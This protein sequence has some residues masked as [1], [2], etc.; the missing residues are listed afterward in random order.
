MYKSIYFSWLFYQF[1]NLTLP[2]DG[3]DEGIYPAG[4]QV[5]CDAVALG[6]I[7]SFELGDNLSR[8]VDHI[9]ADV[10]SLTTHYEGR[11]VARDYLAFAIAPGEVD[12]RR[13]LIGERDGVAICGFAAGL[14]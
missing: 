13:V 9:D 10:L 4:Q 7:L 12:A 6:H 11:T 5:E 8:Q 14:L 1:Q 2:V 3:D